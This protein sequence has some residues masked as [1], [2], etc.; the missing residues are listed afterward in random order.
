MTQLDEKALEV[1]WREMPSP[2]EI[3]VADDA[4]AVRH[5]AA[6][7]ATLPP[8]GDV[9]EIVGRLKGYADFEPTA[10]WKRPWL[11]KAADALTASAARIA[12]LER[13]QDESYSKGLSAGATQFATLHD[14]IDAANARAERLEA[15]LEK[16]AAM[17]EVSV[18]DF[19][20]V[21]KWAHQRI[22]RAALSPA[23]SAGGDDE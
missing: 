6:Y 9:A 10:S 18:T 13:E 8:T 7:L 16:I 15:A 4:A 19:D 1:Y 20:G 22:A 3:S 17:D 11:I 23:P 2:Y 5:I 14:R 21:N 12:E